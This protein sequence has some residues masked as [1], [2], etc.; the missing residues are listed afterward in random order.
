MIYMTAAIV[1][2]EKSPYG[3]GTN[4]NGPAATH[5]KEQTIDYLRASLAYTETGHVF[6]DRRESLGPATTYFGPQL[7]I[8]VAAGLL[9]HSY[10]HYGQ[11]VVYLRMNGVVPP[12]SRV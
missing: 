9:Y 6:A 1:L 7:R 2:E 3:P 8:E 4:D 11:M 5:G 12:A 10:D